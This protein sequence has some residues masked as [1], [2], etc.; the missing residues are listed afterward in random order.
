MVGE[1]AGP[2]PGY[3]AMLPE[4]LRAVREDAAGER[5][6]DRGVR[7]VAPDAGQPAGSGRPVRPLAERARLRL[8]LGLPRR[9]GRPVR[10]GDHREQHERS[11]CRR[12]R[13]STSPTRWPTRRSSGCTACAPRTPSKPWFA[14]FSTGCQP[15]AAPRRRPSGRD[16]YKGEFDQGWDELREE[17]FARQK[18]LG[19]DPGRRGADAADR[20]DAGLG[21][22]DETQQAPL[23]APDGG[24]RRATQENADWNV[25][26]VVDAIEEMGELDN[27]LVIYIWGDNGASMEGTLTGTFNELTMHERHPAHRRAA[28]RSSCS[29]TAASR[30]GARDMMAPHYS[31]GLGLGRQL[32]V[33][34]GQAG[35][36]APRRHA[37]PDG[38]ALAAADRAS[39]AGCAAS[40]PTCIDIGPTILEVAGHPAARR[41]STASSRSRCTAPASPTRFDDADARRAAHAAVLRDPRQPRRC[42]RTAGGCR[43]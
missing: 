11:A 29:S 36:L 26:R 19:V 3:T 40:S 28:A 32:P 42:T 38:R 6:L 39:R 10:P 14:Y 12:R 41:T 7:Q 34:V 16:K 35:R 27:T 15:R 21:L 20:R 25:G 9:R 24:L 4:G 43:R 1:F 5:L 31:A 33:P 17:T 37:Q 18:Q 2:F 23:R 13:T 30:P 8:L 22:A